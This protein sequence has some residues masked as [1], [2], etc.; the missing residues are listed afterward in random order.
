[1]PITAIGFYLLISGATILGFVGY[2]S[3]GHPGSPERIGVFMIAGVMVSL[4]VMLMRRPKAK[5]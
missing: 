1:M 5:P 3:A 2:L 4:G